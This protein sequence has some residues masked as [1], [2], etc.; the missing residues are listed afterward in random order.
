ARAVDN[1]LFVACCSPSRNPESSYQ[2]W[3]HST[4]FGPFGEIIATCEH[5]P[6]I[7]YG[8]ADYAQI[9]ERRSNMPLEKQRR[10]DVYTLV[11]NK[12]LP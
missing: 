7:V 1:Q 10:G 5:S 12:A 3:G 11:D 9:S 8:T 6:S 2:A 4:L